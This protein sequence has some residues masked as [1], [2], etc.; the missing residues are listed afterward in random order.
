MNATWNGIERRGKP[1]ALLDF[2]SRQQVFEVLMAAVAAA[3]ADGHHK[4]AQRYRWQ[5]VGDYVLGA[6]QS[7]KVIIGSIELKL[8]AADYAK[9]CRAA[10]VQEAER[11]LDTDSDA[12]SFYGTTLYGIVRSIEAE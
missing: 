8:S 3:L 12:A 9:A 1:K 10:L 7:A 6:A 2:A 4:V 11:F 5:E